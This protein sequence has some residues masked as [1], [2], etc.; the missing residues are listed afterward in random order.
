M[1]IVKSQ[2]RYSGFDFKF[3]KS[4]FIYRGNN[5]SMFGHLI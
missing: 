2:D 5:F 1:F 3:F 4:N